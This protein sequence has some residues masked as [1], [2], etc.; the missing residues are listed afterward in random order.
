MIRSK[1]L[2]ALVMA[3]L[4]TFGAALP[5]SAAET[6]TEIT[7]ITESETQEVQ[8]PDIL[9]AA[10]SQTLSDVPE[11]DIDINALMP[12]DTTMNNILSN[13]PQAYSTDDELFAIQIQELYIVNKIRASYGI[14]LLAL[15]DSLTDAA[16]GPR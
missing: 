7:E 16:I 6:E 14:D 11:K 5:V 13:L 15:G 10:G 1:K 12:N 8:Q 9:E 2:L 4:M 3:G